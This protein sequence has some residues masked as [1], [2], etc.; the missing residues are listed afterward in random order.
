MRRVF[1]LAMVAAC[2]SGGPSDIAPTLRLADRSDAELAR[3]VSAAGGTDMFAAQA[4]VDQFSFATDPCPAIALAGNSATIT[5]GCTTTGGVAVDGTAT[6]ANSPTWSQTAYNFG[7]D[8]TYDLHGLTLT[9]A[10]IVQT[11]DGSIRMTD[12]L[13]T[14]DA[15][16]TATMLGI[17]VRS[18]LSI[19]C[20]RGSQSCSL[21][22]SG[23]ELVGAGGVYVSGT[24]AV[25]GMTASAQLALHG[26]DT[27]TATITNGCIAYQISGSARAKA[28]P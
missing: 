24:V 23:L 19:H 14:W 5:G 17:A 20:D 11:F 12:G 25:S 6:I 22:S 13:A 4:Q 1:S 10:T 21:S 3:L 28:C 15:N 18:E 27:L 9:E 26:A 2:G 16:V 7:A 8:T